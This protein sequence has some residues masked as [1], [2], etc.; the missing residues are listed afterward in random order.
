[1]RES[2][3]FYAQTRRDQ[4]E[5][6]AWQ[7]DRVGRRDLAA[8]LRAGGEA[9]QVDAVLQEAT[10]ALDEASPGLTE[11]QRR[12]VR[13]REAEIHLRWVAFHW[14]CMARQADQRG[15][16][17]A[18]RHDYLGQEY[19]RLASC[20]ILP[21]LAVR[22]SGPEDPAQGPPTNGPAD[23]AS[24]VS[25]KCRAEF[26]AA[27]YLALGPLDHKGTS[28]AEPG[29]TPGDGAAGLGDTKSRSVCRVAE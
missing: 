17:G 1:M 7:L 27:V 4:A 6:L 11:A 15:L 5:L 8:R 21:P 19:K 25:K 9:E 18:A 16:V 20:G 2:E 3:R 23:G 22:H 12:I 13:R 29:G 10:A 28:P 14:R 26:R 24:L